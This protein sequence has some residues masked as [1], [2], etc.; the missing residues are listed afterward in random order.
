LLNLPKGYNDP[1]ARARRNPEV[2]SEF[3]REIEVNNA[4]VAIA[5]EE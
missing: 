3:L 2:L 4:A 1:G 5:V